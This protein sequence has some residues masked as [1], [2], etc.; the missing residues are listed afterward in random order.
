[1]VDYEASKKGLDACYEL[2]KEFQLLMGEPSAREPRTLSDDRLA[3]R[4]EWLIGEVSEMQT[5]KDLVGQVDALC[6]LMYFC[7]GSLVEMGVPPGEAFSFVHKA[8]LKKLWPDGKAKIDSSG[9]IMKPKGWVGPEA[10]IE[11]YL[12]ELREKREAERERHQR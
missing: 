3:R 6:D 8:N 10:E 4:C 1:M 12:S 9:R 2:V 11:R 5:S 7:L